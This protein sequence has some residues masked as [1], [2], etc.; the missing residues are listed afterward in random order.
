MPFSKVYQTS[1]ILKKA[2]RCPLPTAEQRNHKRKA[3]PL[4]FVT[5]PYVDFGKYL[6]LIFAMPNF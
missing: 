3:M 6:I 1:T 2:P 5:S 4:P